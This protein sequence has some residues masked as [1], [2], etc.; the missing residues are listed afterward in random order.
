MDNIARNNDTFNQRFFNVVNLLCLHRP[1]AIISVCNLFMRMSN[2]G[3][4]LEKKCVWSAIFLKLWKSYTRVNLSR[5]LANPKW[6][7]YHRQ[8]LRYHQNGNQTDIRSWL[9]HSQSCDK[10]TIGHTKHTKWVGK[11]SVHTFERSPRG[12]TVIE[13]CR[14]R[15]IIS[16]VGAAGTL[17]FWWK[18]GLI[19][20]TDHRN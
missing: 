10:R 4:F 15:W 19:S 11:G 14:T 9:R 1:S 5:S 2:N 7:P 3:S 12:L 6:H 17:V 16:V 8:F 13:T 18:I 20:I